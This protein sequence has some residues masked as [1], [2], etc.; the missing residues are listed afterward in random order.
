M[1]K[2]SRQHMR[3]IVSEQARLCLRIGL[4]QACYRSYDC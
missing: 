1:G 2:A 3:F 4:S